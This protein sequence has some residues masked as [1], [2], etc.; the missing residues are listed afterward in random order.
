M[1]QFSCLVGSG[2]SEAA[3]LRRDFQST[4]RQFPILGSLPIIGTLFRSTGFN[5]DETELVIVVTPRLIRPV[6][7]QNL[8]LPTD[9]VK[10][11]NEADLFLLGRP[12]TGVPPVPEFDPPLL[13]RPITTAPAAPAP[14]GGSAERK[15]TGFEKEYG[16]EL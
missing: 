13:G 12:D 9:R 1:I 6:R 3:I 2:M 5:R 7:P 15:P 4:V 8:K 11:P 14:A 10:P 16:H